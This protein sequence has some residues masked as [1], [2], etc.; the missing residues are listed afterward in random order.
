MDRKLVFLLLA[1]CSTLG[2]QSRVMGSFPI[3]GPVSVWQV[4]TIANSSTNLLI[5]KPDGSTTTVAKAAATTQSVSL[6]TPGANFTLDGCIVKTSTAFVGP[7]T[8]TATVGITGTLTGCVSVAYDMKAVVS[9]TNFGLPTL[10]TAATSTNGTDAIIL[11]LTTT[12][13]NITTIST[14]TVVVWLRFV[15]LP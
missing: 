12:I 6:V 13:D 15:L 10:V 3:P 14:G 8:L 7:T 4:Y 9:A 11:A 1:V 5:T 2:G